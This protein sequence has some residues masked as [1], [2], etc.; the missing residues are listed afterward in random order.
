MVK[1]FMK[2]NEVFG[3]VVIEVGCKYFFGYLIIL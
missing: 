1:I 2:G 3:K